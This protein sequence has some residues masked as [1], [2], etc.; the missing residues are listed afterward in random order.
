MSNN[1]FIL[2][3]NAKTVLKK[4]YYYYYYY[5]FASRLIISFARLL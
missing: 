4:L 2:V 5:C 1:P 3:S